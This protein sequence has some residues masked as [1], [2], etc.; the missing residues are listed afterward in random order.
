MWL[1]MAITNIEATQNLWQNG[2]KNGTVRICVDLKKLNIAVRREHLMVSSLDDIAPKL[3]YS[4][5]FSTLDATMQWILANPARREQPADDDIY[6]TFWA[7][8]IPLTAFRH[9]VSAWN[10]PEENVATSW[11]SV[12]RRSNYGRHSRSRTG[13]RR[14]WRLL[15]GCDQKNRRIRAK[16]QPQQVWTATE[17]ATLLW[18]HHHW[19][20]CQA[21]SS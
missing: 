9:F 6:H 3:A 4:K 11:R 16:A 18:T 5:V 21:R 19:E 10:I 13:P 15:D 20:Q 12:G 17:R 1:I 14:T 2:E 8:R 7:L